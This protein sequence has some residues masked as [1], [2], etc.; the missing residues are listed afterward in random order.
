M[1]RRDQDVDLSDL[2]NFANG[3]PHDLSSPSCDS[4]R[5]VFFH[6]PTDR[7]PGGEGFWVLTRHA[8]VLAAAAD[9]TTLSSH[10]G[11][12]RTDGGTLIEDLPDGLAAGVL[13]NMMDDPRH[14]LLRRS[15]LAVCDAESACATRSG[16]DPSS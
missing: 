11:G 15:T 7:T 6:E 16:L 9:A 13:L 12:P 1:I 2:D 10:R 5:P 14:N 4:E 3:F 8:D